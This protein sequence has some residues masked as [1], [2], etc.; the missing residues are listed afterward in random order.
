MRNRMREQIFALI[1]QDYQEFSAKLL[2]GVDNIL[3]VRLPELRKMAK[4][5]A[6]GD[7]RTYLTNAE[8]EY[9]EE[10]MLQG[11]VIGYVKTDIEEILAYTA[12][13]VPK[14]D[15][16]S[17]CDSFCSSLKITKQYRGRMW[18]FLQAYVASKKE[19]EIR[20][21]IVMFLHYY[22]EDE[23]ID[24]VLEILDRINHEAYYVKMAVAWAV[25]ICYVKHPTKT[26]EYLRGNP[27]DDFTYNKALQKITESLRVDKETKALIRRMRR[28]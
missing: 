23:Y 24:D 27:L 26:M 28:R 8:S 21:G 18:K 5:I 25:S 19:Y 12:A 6:N 1:D 14:I 4:D 16:W 9:F 3:G 15:N 11:M 7:W 10:I 2:P 13:F 20:F 22:I 17:V